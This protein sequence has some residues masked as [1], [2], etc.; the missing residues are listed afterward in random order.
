MYVLEADTR[1]RSNIYIPLYKEIMN[2]LHYEPLLLLYRI[3]L[4]NKISEPIP[5]PKDQ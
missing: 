4:A 1:K 2:N 3:I 5:A